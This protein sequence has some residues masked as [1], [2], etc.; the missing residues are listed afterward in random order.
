MTRPTVVSLPPRSPTGSSPLIASPGP[1]GR[2]PFRSAVPFYVAGRLDYPS[3][4]IADVAAALQLGPLE[5]GRPARV[6]DLGCGPGFLALGFAALDCAVVAMD[7]EPE[8]LD[9]ARRAADAA[10]ADI[11]FVAGGSEDLSPT[12]GRFDLVTM[13]RSF[14]WMDREKTLVALDALVEPKGGIALFRDGHPECPEND[15]HEAWR[16]VRRRYVAKTRHLAPPRVDPDSGHEDVLERSA[17]SDLERLKQRYRRRTSVAQIVDRALSMSSCSPERLG[18]DRASFEAELRA[19]LAPY[20]SDGM[21][22]E[23]VEAEALLARRPG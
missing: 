13:G 21:I 15:W 8:M 18:A 4:L 20:A 10:G 3:D 9:A 22:E 11:E 12:L 16:Q 17:F 23:T 1:P 5:L 2:R 7:P 6:L 14:H 19:A